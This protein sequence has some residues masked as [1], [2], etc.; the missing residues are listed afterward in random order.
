MFFEGNFGEV[1]RGRYRN[2]PVAVKVLRETNRQ[3]TLKDRTNFVNEALL[4]K[5]YKHKQIV[6][7][8]GIAAFH[9]PLMI[10]MELV[11][12]KIEDN[13]NCSI[14]CLLILRRKFEFLFTEKS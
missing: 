10:V 8:Y 7:F 12:S 9:E 14:I 1:H 11:E 4:L 6:S 3:L 5:S 13:Q 2:V